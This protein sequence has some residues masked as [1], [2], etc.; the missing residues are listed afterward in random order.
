MRVEVYWNIRQRMF[1]IKALEGPNKGRVVDRDIRVELRAVT[2]HVSQ[3]GRR[4]VLEEQRKNVHAV[5][6]GEW[7]EDRSRP[8][9]MRAHVMVRYNP[10]RDQT[11]NCDGKAVRRAAWVELFTIQS[12]NGR[13]AHIAAYGASD[14]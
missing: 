13:T 11:F 4:R 14:V 10:Y 8:S 2:F 3:A 7:V 9:D 1:S 6:R 5:L 12:A